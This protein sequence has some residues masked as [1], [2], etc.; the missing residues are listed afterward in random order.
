MLTAK[1]LYI[2]LICFLG[3]HCALVFLACAVPNPS[4]FLS[5]KWNQLIKIEMN[6]GGFKAVTTSIR[7]FLLRVPLPACGGC[8]AVLFVPELIDSRHPWGRC[9]CFA[10]WKVGCWAAGVPLAWPC[11]CWWRECALTQWL[12]C[13]PGHTLGTHSVD[14]QLHEEDVWEIKELQALGWDGKKT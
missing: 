12:L 13:L 11:C 3:I 7:I 14:G 2:S 6:T 8:G 9:L 5:S 4:N 1:S 10:C